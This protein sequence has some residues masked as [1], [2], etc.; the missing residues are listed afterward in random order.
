MNSDYHSPSTGAWEV[1]FKRSTCYQYGLEDLEYRMPLSMY[2][3]VAL[4]EKMESG[5]SYM[6]PDAVAEALIHRYEAHVQP[7]SYGDLN[8]GN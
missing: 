1:N 6:N 4:V 5:R 8:R 2:N 7:K 3:L